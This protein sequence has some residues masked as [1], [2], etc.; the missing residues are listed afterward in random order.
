MRR[1]VLLS[2]LLL[3]LTANTRAQSFATVSVLDFGETPFAKQTAH[4]LRERLRTTVELLVA[5][6]DLTRAAAKGIGYSG[7]LN[8]SL[9]EARDLGAA[10]ATEFYILGDAQTLRR[11]SSAR[12]VYYESYCSLF[13]V[14]ARTGRLIMWNRPSF[15]NDKASEAEERLAK[16]L[17]DE[18]VYRTGLAIRRARE[19]E[20]R[21]R[22]IPA[23]TSEPLIAEAPDDETVAEVHI[24]FLV[25]IQRVVKVWREQQARSIEGVHAFAGPD[26]GHAIYPQFDSPYQ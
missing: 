20:R 4:N 15:E 10:L 22:I 21:L 2:G 12:P 11:S 16:E 1:L 24:L 13:L 25:L 6:P 7:S 9:S 19:D 14:S 3:L 5:D 23:E 8:L 17:S 26:G 18:T